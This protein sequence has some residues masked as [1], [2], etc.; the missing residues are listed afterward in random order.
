MLK[1]NSLTLSLIILVTLCG[2]GGAEQKMSDD[3]KKV[4]AF[5]DQMNLKDQTELSA[6]WPGWVVKNSAYK[7]M[8]DKHSLGVHWGYQQAG[9]YYEIIPLDKTEE[10][11]VSR[12]VF[13]SGYS[14]AIQSCEARYKELIEGGK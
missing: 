8:T 10:V 4:Q 9:W 2:C 13:F 14:A 1:F 6:T 5:E 12:P 7:R 3:L 11:I